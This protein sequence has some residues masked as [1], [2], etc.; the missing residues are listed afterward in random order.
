MINFASDNYAPTHPDVLRALVDCNQDPAPSYGR[1]LYTEK[2]ESVFK[3]HFGKSTESFLVWNGTAAN[4]LG[5]NALLSSY[6]SILCSDLSHIA[7]DECGAPERHLG[8]KLQTIKTPD[9]KLTPELIE[10]YLNRINDVHASQPKVI[11]ITQ[12]TEYGTV[13]STSEIK[14]LVKLAHEKDLYV[15]LDGARIANAALS[16]NQPF[17]AFTTDLGV[18]VLSFGGTKN[19]LMGAEAVIF[20]DAS[21]IPHFPYLRKQGMHLSS[22]MRYLS[23]QFLAYFEND[24][25]KKNASHANQMAKLLESK[26]LLIPFVKINQKVEANAVFASLPKEII[27]KLQKQFSFYVWN[28]SKNEVR[29]MCSFNTTEKEIEL[30]ASAIQSS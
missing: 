20:R 17:S 4:V 10:P 15:H 3:E 9:A 30:F 29:L 5:L 12:S 14:A 28:E 19:G 11:S 13:Y 1:D 16:L 18:D 22:K 27:F 6:Q 23:A 8:S 25:W 24:L 26:L 21:L 7:V 2:L